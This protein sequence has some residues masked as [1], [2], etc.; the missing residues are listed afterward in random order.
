MNMEHSLG[1]LDCPACQY[2]KTATRWS[3]RIDY[4][5]GTF[6]E[7]EILAPN[8]IQATQ[9]VNETIALG[10]IGE[11]GT[12]LDSIFS[13]SIEGKPEEWVDEPTGITYRVD[14]LLGGERV[15]LISPDVVEAIKLGLSK[16]P[17]H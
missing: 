15:I 7:E 10:A 13:V 6:W 11:H 5:D 16:M 9:I 12:P 14:P 17:R 8:I 4:R 1:H 3:A 2:N